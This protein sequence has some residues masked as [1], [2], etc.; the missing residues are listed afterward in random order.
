MQTVNRPTSSWSLLEFLQDQS[1]NI[2]NVVSPL[3]WTGL[4][5]AVMDRRSVL[6]TWYM[7][8]LGFFAALLANSVPI[9][10]GIVYIPALS[11]LGVQLTLGASFTIGTMPFGN[12]MFG[13]L[14]WMSKDPRVFVWD[15]FYYTVIPS[16]VGSIIAM[17]LL[18][19]PDVVLI[20]LSF[21]A[22]CFLLS[23]LVLFSMYRGGLKEVLH[24]WPSSYQPSIVRTEGLQF[25]DLLGN[26]EGELIKDEEFDTEVK[27]PNSNISHPVPIEDINLH[28]NKYLIAAVSFLGGVILVPNIG[29]GP[30]L[31]TYFLL[32]L[33]GYSDQQALVTG[34]VTGGWVCIVPFLYHVSILE[35]VPYRL[36]VMVLPG[37]FLGAKVDSQTIFIIFSS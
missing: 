5:V 28:D 8:F 37:V 22:F 3:V 7:P 35:D 14:R 19:S 4:F 21:G 32:S 15:S 25:S 27:L 18:P 29:I 36:W 16:W 2:L 34:I 12:G 9:G 26:E 30:A 1:D 20:K 23:I 6:E 13:F 11:L 33:L 17:T 10:G 24:S 31:V